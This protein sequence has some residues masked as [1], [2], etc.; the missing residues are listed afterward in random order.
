M[1]AKSVFITVGT[2]RFDSLVSATLSPPFLSLLKSQGFTTLKLQHGNSSLPTTSSSFPITTTTYPF[3]P[4]LLPDMLSA[5]LII[6]HAGSGSIFESLEARKRLLV[7][8][9]TELM[10]N[11]QVELAE[12]LAEEGVLAWCTVESL[13]DNVERRVWEK[14]KAYGTRNAE[15]FGVAVRE[16][17]GF[18]VTKAD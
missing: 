8:V 4:T 11:H 10:D 5:D 2:T 15:A 17:M 18:A 14:C 16:E 13:L 12:A 9:N 1:S 3:K 7:V 6:S